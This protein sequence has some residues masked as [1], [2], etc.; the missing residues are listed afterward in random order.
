MPVSNYEPGSD[1]D[2]FQMELQPLP[3]APVTTVAASTDL[4]AVE[5]ESPF[6]DPSTTY[7]QAIPVYVAT[8][9][10]TQTVE[11]SSTVAAQNDNAFLSRPFTR[12]SPV[13]VGAKGQNQENTPPPKG[14]PLSWIKSIWTKPQDYWGILSASVLVIILIISLPLGYGLR[15]RPFDVVEQSPAFSPNDTTVRAI[16]FTRPHSSP[17]DLSCR[18]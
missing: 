16:Y 18:C 2:I 11:S 7:D 10:S 12:N 14:F 8:G 4:R 3:P 13:V 17:I 15:Q 9:P 5:N 6:L 1:S